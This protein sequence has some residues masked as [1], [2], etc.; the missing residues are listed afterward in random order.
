MTRPQPSWR[1]LLTRGVL[2][3]A[4]LTAAAARP[5]PSD[6]VEAPPVERS[7]VVSERF[8]LDLE[9][10]QV[11]ADVRDTLRAAAGR[12]FPCEADFRAFLEQALGGGALAAEVERDLTLSE[13]LLA[14]GDA[15]IDAV[16]GDAEPAPNV[17]KDALGAEAFQAAFASGEYQYVGNLKCRVCHRDYFLGRKKDA[18]STA[19]R[20]LVPKRLGTEARCLAC[21]ATGNGVAGGYVDDLRTKDLADVR[22]EGCHGPGSKHARLGARGG[23]LAGQ[24]S[25]DVLKRMC[26]GCHRGRW[27]RSF[28]D[29][30]VAYDLYKEAEARANE[31]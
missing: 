13:L 2:L 25:P 1:R 3:L 18:H 5:A 30:D 19:Q 10:Q 20:R 9:H 14:F 31:R 21:H 17:L 15:R 7:F 24:D 8:L 26:A 29:I 16:L 22:C 6:G 4:V 27:E 12:T 23:L 28:V 11:A